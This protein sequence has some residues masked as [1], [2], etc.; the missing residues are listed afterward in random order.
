MPRRAAH[1]VIGTIGGGEGASDTTAPTVVI[2]CA[3]TSPSATT[4]LNFTFTANEN[5]TDFDISKITVGG[6][7]GTKSNFAGSGMV[8]TCDIAPTASGVMTVDVAAGAFHDGAGNTNT[9]ATQFTFTAIVIS[10]K[11]QFTTDDAAPMTSPRTCEPTGALTV[12]DTTNLMSISGGKLVWTGRNAQ[13]DPM[14]RTASALYAR[15]IGLAISAKVDSTKEANV[16]LSP[17][18]GSYYLDTH[19]NAGWSAGSLRIGD[20]NPIVQGATAGI[21]PIYVI[22]RTKGYLVIQDVGGTK[23]LLFVYGATTQAIDANLYAVVGAVNN[24]VA[25]EADNLY[26]ARLPAPYAT[27]TGI[28]TNSSASP[29]S[30]DE[31][32]HT[33][34]CHVEVEWVATTGATAELWLRRTDA[35]NGWVVRCDQGGS[36]IK[37]IQKQGGVETERSSAAQTWTNT[38][39]YRIYAIAY[40]NNIYT[41]AIAYGGKDAQKNSYTSATF[42]NTATIGKVVASAGALTNFVTWPRTLSGTALSILQAAFP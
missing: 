22:A 14:V 23:T 17:V 25:G 41:Y 7:G 42:N 36:T 20:G 13:S 27:D 28:V 5:T 32:T 15:A 37:L 11:D 30:N 6:V 16:K 12:V 10:L 40:G 39:K 4:P 29:A 35:D 24:N 31:L 26:V 8:Y 21:N 2:T 3:Q 33:A 1:L 9:A 19:D 34:D 18:A 38:T